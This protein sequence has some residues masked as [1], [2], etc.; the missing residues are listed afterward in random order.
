MR[1]ACAIA[2]QSQKTLR[3]CSTAAA[4]PPPQTSPSLPA[5]LPPHNRCGRDSLNPKIVSILNLH[6]CRK[7]VGSN[8][9]SSHPY[10]C[11]ETAM[12]FAHKH[13][14]PI[15]KCKNGDFW[16]LAMLRAKDHVTPLLEL[17]PP[18]E[19]KTELQKLDANINGINRSWGSRRFFLDAKWR[20][21]V[22]VPGGIHIVEAAHDR[23]RAASL[24]AV[25]VT[26]F[27]RSPA[28]QAAVRN[29]IS[30]DG[31]GVVI[32]ISPQHFGNLGTLLGGLLSFLGVAPQQ[33]DLIIDF[34]HIGDNAAAALMP[35]MMHTATMA[36]PTLSAWRTITVAAG[37]FPRNL[38][39]LSQGS[40]NTL[41]RIEWQ[42]WCSLIATPPPRLPSYGDYTIG[43]PGL[44][45]S[46]PAQFTASLRYSS[47]SDFFVW[48]GF[49]VRTHARGYQQI[50]DICA[51]LI[52]LPQYS[53]ST[54]SEGD[55]EIQLK[56]AMIGS[57][58][59]PE[60]WRKWCTNHYLELVAS[61]IASLP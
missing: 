49:S 19:K 45:F 6:F 41:P 25:P 30:R 52:T 54:F 3:P 32:R 20:Q 17:T 2:S 48:R 10:S 5:M 27:D 31:H 12:T 9:P 39:G 11:S 8:R 58:G 43:D 4:A 40:W 23:A 53:G 7:Y 16:S 36:V 37:S 38:T 14:V 59:N 60:A 57:P 22:I 42:S 35:T 29:V 26:A 24:L 55:S 13:Y 56:A 15:L 46:G 34:D 1:S 50:F 28:F 44:P 21:N 18:S 47:G 61:Q 51:D 33:V